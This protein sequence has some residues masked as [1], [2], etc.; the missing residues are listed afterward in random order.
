MERMEVG[1][2][3]EH[4]NLA[5]IDTTIYGRLVKPMKM[6]GEEISEGRVSVQQYLIKEGKEWKVITADDRTRAYFLRENPN[7]ARDFSLSSPRLAYKRNGEW[8]TL[9]QPTAV[10]PART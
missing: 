4:G 3:Q 5:V 6:Q 2:V 10:S 1:K 9:G 7:F 8:Q